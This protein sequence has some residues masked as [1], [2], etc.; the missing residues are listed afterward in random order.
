[1]AKAK[2]TR[3][4]QGY[5]STIVWDGTYDEHGRKHRIHL[6]SRKSSAD[7]EEKVQKLKLK[8]DDGTL[9]LR[10]EKTIESYAADWIQTKVVLSQNTQRQYK[11]ILKYYVIPTIGCIRVNDL[12]KIH[13]QTLISNNA[14]HP[15]TCQLIRRTVLQIAESAVDDRLLPE[16]SIRPLRSVKLPSYHKTE[17][18]VLTKQEKAAIMSA[19]FTPMQRCF[20]YLLFY[21]GLRR[22]EALA[23]MPSDIDLNRLCVRVSRSCEF[24]G[25]SSSIKAPK[26]QRGYRTVPMTPQLAEFLRD[27][28]PTVPGDYLVHKAD[29]SLMTQ[30]AFRRMWEQILDK[31]N[32]AAGAK[33]NVKVIS[34]LTPHIFRHNLCTELCYQIPALSTKKIAAIM[35]HDESMVIKIYSHIL[36]DKEDAPAAFSSIFGAQKVE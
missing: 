26:S 8:R 3:D 17:R 36:E 13:L 20:V 27:Y 11:E 31:M 2:Y 16:N 10:S 28:L 12:S 6:R 23:I 19:D 7:L 34:G 22:G 25:T 9:V 33:K 4:K 35:G 15:R 14:D 5:F 29:G 1:M 21:C 18:R 24:V 32:R 30:S